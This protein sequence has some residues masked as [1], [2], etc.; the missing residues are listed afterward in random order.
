MIRT[1]PDYKNIEAQL[2]QNERNYLE[3]RAALENLKR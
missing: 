2:L 3:A 1:H